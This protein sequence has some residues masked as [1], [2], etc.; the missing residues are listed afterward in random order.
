M[1][2]L[3]LIA[4]LMMAFLAAA[5]APTRLKPPVVSESFTVLPCPAKPK[6]TV[7][8]EGCAEHRIVRSDKAINEQVS[9]IFS[10]LEKHRSRAAQAR[11]VRGERAWL[12]YRRAVCASRADLYEG[13][14]GAPVAFADCEVGI[15]AAHLKE[16]R[17]FASELR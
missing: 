10:L 11:F 15:N 7:D 9:R 6:T 1:V 14:S 3:A 5:A 2:R 16:L 13:G 17:I 4:P 12:V 8:L